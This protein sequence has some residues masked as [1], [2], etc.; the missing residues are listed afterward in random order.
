MLIFSCFLPILFNNLQQYFQHGK[1]DNQGY[2]KDDKSRL[3][4]IWQ[5]RQVKF[6]KIEG[7]RKNK[8]NWY[9]DDAFMI[10]TQKIPQK[11]YGNRWKPNRRPKRKVPKRFLFLSLSISIFL[12]TI[13]F[14]IISPWVAIIANKMKTAKINLP[15]TFQVGTIVAK[16][17]S[18]WRSCGK[19]FQGLLFKEDSKTY[20]NWESVKSTRWKW[21]FSWGP[22]QNLFCGSTKQIQQR[23]QE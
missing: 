19:K 5:I 20:F 17:S 21:T 12:D 15:E 3:C 1:W 22:F 7:R 6:Y 18:S 23:F 11:R 10:S 9:I 4:K 2:C 13:A 14:V 16:L 8:V